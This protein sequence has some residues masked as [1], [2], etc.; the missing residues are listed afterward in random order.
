MGSIISV[1]I[2]VKVMLTR[3]LSILPSLKLLSEMKNN[4]DGTATRP[5]FPGA[6]GT[7]ACLF[8]F[9]FLPH[10]ETIFKKA[11]GRMSNERRSECCKCLSI[12]K[13]A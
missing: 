3:I 8:F 10:A 5:N 11:Q 9:F 7:S 13:D 6:Q 12:K 4:S 2:I 1:L